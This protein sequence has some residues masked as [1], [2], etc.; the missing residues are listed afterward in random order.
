MKTF[1]EVNEF[2]TE[3]LWQLDLARL[4]RARRLFF[5][6]LRLLRT[7]TERFILNRC[8]LQA[9]AL[10]YTT[11]LSLVPLLAL[12]FSILKGLGVQNQ[13]ESVLL[14]KLSAGSEEMVSQ[15]IRY[16]DRTNVKTLGVLGL[17]GLVIMAISVIGNVEIAMN[18]IWGVQKARS[19]GRKLSDYL[20]VL[21]IVPVLSV[22]AMGLTSF[23]H[24]ITLL[25]GALRFPGVSEVV[26]LLAMVFPYLLIWIALTFLYAYLPNTIVAPR[27]ALFGAVTAG[28]LWQLT[29]WAY[30]HFQIGVAKYNAIYGAFAEV[31]ILLVWLY[32]GWAIILFGAAIAFAHQNLRIHGKNTAAAAVCYNL[33]EEL[34]L[35]LLLLI[36]RNFYS[37]SEPWS[38]ERLSSALDMPHS[39]V[40]EILTGYCRAG[41]LM[42]AARGRIERFLLA[43]APEKLRLDELVEILRNLGERKA[44]INEIEGEEIL[45][46]T[47]AKLFA[48]RRNLLSHLTL[49]DI[50]TEIPGTQ[51]ASAPSA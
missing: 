14:E 49:K 1:K 15:I 51:D 46:E 5:R 26:I 3:E 31:P 43:K 16:I 23:I 19:L 36:A 7:A 32:A 25:R 4:P 33:R 42:P 41:I 34:G 10:T 18:N 12:M 9:S 11:L 20:T 29:Q 22:A 27:S 6:H 48:S 8:L 2:F 47:L 28:T 21:L 13:L 24:S 38:A 30:I 45:T 17:I 40:Y 35:K 37:D 44:K 50:L 39:L